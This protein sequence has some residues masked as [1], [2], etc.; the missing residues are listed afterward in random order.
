[1]TEPRAPFLP[2]RE[3]LAWAAGFFD[4]EGHIG[5]VKTVGKVGGHVNRRLHINVCQTQEGPLERL[6]AVLGVGR[7]YGPYPNRDSNGGQRK[8]YR[9][10]HIDGVEQVQHAIAALWPWLSRPK[11]NQAKTA[12]AE[13]QDYLARPK[14]PCG[15]KTRPPQ[16]ASCHPERRCHARG[17]CSAC[18]QVRRRAERRAEVA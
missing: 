5:C 10:F 14:V 6:Q 9:Q 2:D 17:L 15:P 8:P 7:I 11:R 3:Q 12:F 4:G 16:F 13:F 1:M 18:Y